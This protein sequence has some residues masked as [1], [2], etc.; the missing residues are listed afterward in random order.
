MANKVFVTVL[1]LALASLSSAQRTGFTEIHDTFNQQYWYWNVTLI[2][3]TL[4]KNNHNCTTG[5]CDLSVG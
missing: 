5:Y 4:C 3:T 2:G 1:L